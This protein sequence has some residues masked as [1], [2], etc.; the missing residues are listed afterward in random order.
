MIGV[1]NNVKNYMKYFMLNNKSKKSVLAFSLVEL[2][3]VMVV[4]GLLIFATIGGQKIVDLVRISR[5]RQLTNS[6]SFVL[7]KSLV[8]WLEPTLRNS[9]PVAISNEDTVSQWNNLADSDIN[10]AQAT[11]ANRPIFV[12]DGIGR[13]PSVRFDGSN[14]YLE[15]SANSIVSLNPNK[16][17]IFVVISVSSDASSTKYV[18]NSLS[19][20][21]GYELHLS[22]SN[23]FVSTISGGSSTASSALSVNI[24]YILNADYNGSSLSSYLNNSLVSSSSLSFSRNK[25]FTPIIGAQGASSN[26][27]TGDISE[28]IIYDE[29][30]SDSERGEIYDYL[31]EKYKVE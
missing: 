13:I 3:V 4:I 6:A 25:S 16:F 12:S 15:F 8:L 26:P 14:D 18:F 9:F 27:F 2:S 28:I 21:D 5:A 10:P 19:S 30:L 24:P 7:K 29:A 17:T 1:I 11:S 31:A 23:Q 22:T 20:G